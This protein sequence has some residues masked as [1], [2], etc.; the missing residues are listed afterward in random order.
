MVWNFVQLVAEDLYIK[1]LIGVTSYFLK[2]K[3]VHLFIHKWIVV[4]T[5]CIN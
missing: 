2:A 3:Q 4:S 5:M 1:F